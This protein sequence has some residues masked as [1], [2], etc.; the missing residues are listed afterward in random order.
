MAETSSARRRK[1]RRGKNGAVVA[2]P[3]LAAELGIGVLDKGKARAVPPTAANGAHSADDVADAAPMAVTSGISTSMSKSKNPG[4]ATSLQNS[5]KYARSRPIVAENVCRGSRWHP[6]TLLIAPAPAEQEI[7]NT[8]ELSGS[9]T[10][11][12]GSCCF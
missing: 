3:S 8:F 2:A 6:L 7:G 4:Y 9:L 12:G 1:P 10:A 11:Y 5:A